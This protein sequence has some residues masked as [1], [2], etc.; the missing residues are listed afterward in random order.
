MIKLENVSFSY[1]NKK[2]VLN[3]LNIEFK[4]GEITII[5]GK[6]GSGKTT[7]CNLL[8]NFLKYQGNIYLDDLNFK[9]IKNIDFRKKVG[10]VFQ[11]PNNQIIFN[12][13]IDDLNFTLDNLNI[14]NKDKIT[15]SLERLNMLSYL[16]SN[17]Y[18]L[19]L[20]E[21]QRINFATLLAINPDCFILDETT[22]MIDNNGKNIIYNLIKELKKENKAIIMTTNIID[23]LLLA[24]RIL[25][26]E[27]GI[28]KYII[29]KKDL[30]NNLDKLKEVFPD[31]SFK[32]KVLDILKDKL[33]YFDDS[34]VINLIGNICKQ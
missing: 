17:P 24:D 23:E 4:K 21:K 2:K 1:N 14:K 30:F 27:N 34:E 11:N 15:S 18:E 25:I 31:L 6:N 5:I 28:I 9:K 20:G 3:N 19:S 13:V 7:I 33:N 12:R 32:I 10:I 16:N 22:S 29:L 8:G 26:L